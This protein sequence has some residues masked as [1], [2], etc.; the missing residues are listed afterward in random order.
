VDTELTRSIFCNQTEATVAS[1]ALVRLGAVGNVLTTK[2]ELPIDF[3][4]MTLLIA[5]IATITKRDDG[6]LPS[7]LL[8]DFEI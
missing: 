3:F 8:E 4:G 7:A 2:F 1:T 6:M 5:P